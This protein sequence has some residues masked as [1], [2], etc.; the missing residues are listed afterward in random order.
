[1]RIYVHTLIGMQFFCFFF[2][3]FNIRLF[4]ARFTCK[5]NFDI[6]KQAGRDKG[7]ENRK[8]F[9]VESRRNDILTIPAL[10][11]DKIGIK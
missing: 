7:I 2:L 9:G 4:L 11:H 8:I 1:M 5:I 10:L 6:D 3:F